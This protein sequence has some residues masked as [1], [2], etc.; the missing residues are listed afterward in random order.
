M[1]C[2]F[3]VTLN[4][5]LLVFI[6]DGLIISQEP[7]SLPGPISFLQFVMM[8]SPLRPSCDVIDTRMQWKNL[9]TFRTGMRCYYT[10]TDSRLEKDFAFQRL[11]DTVFCIAAKI[12]QMLSAVIAVLESSWSTGVKF[13]VKHQSPLTDAGTLYQP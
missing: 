6:P 5:V 13:G 8:Q 3:V 1:A 4:T 9:I 7:C 10:G 11:L 2:L 12:K